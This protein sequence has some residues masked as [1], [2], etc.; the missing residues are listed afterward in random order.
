M[1]R[2]TQ[3]PTKIFLFVMVVKNFNEK[4][5]G[6]CHSNQPFNPRKQNSSKNKLSGH[7]STWNR[8]HHHQK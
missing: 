2:I 6:P 7:L 5:P 1:G 4:Q 8:L 3:V